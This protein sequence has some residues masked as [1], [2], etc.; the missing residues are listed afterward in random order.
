MLMRGRL[1]MGWPKQIRVQIYDLLEPYLF[2]LRCRDIL[3]DGVGA[4][5]LRT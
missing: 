5:G 3:D 2:I 4:N 1:C